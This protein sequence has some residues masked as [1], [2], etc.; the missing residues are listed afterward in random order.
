MAPSSNPSSL[1][2]LLLCIPSLSFSNTAL[3]LEINGRRSSPS[4][5]DLR[6]WPWRREAVPRNEPAAGYFLPADGGGSMLTKV[7]GT[8]PAGQGEPINIILTGTSSPEL[9]VDSELNGGLRNFFLSFGFASECLGQHSGNGQGANLGDGKGYLNET[10]VIRFDYGDPQLG[11]CQE[12]IKGGNHF[13]YW[14]QNGNSADSGAVFMAASYEMPIAQQHNVVVNGYNL[15]RDWLIGNI[16]KSA[17]PSASLTNTSTFSGTTQYGGYTYAASI[18]YVSGLLSNTS[19][20]IN[21]NA[22]VSVG[23]V[24]AIDGLVAVMDVQITAK[25]AN[26]TSSAGWRPAPSPILTLPLLL[27]GALC[28]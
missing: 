6:F 26:A 24:P 4:L 14:A 19:D 1:F 15:G 22:T 7:V 11:T 10:A 17:I 8:F 21:H 20:G 12:T 28:I 25:P 2:F 13:R 23:G 9:L 3:A 5:L 27:L 16:T 18:A